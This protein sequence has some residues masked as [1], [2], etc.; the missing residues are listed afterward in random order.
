MDGIA[1]FKEAQEGWK[2]FALWKPSPF[3]LPRLVRFVTVLN[4]I[5][6]VAL[7]ARQSDQTGLPVDP[8]PEDLN[9]PLIT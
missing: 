6:R 1:Q 3:R 9:R 8:C 2:H 5:W 4:S 7:H